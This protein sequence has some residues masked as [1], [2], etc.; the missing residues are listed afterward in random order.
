VNNYKKVT[1]KEVDE[2]VGFFVDTYNTQKLDCEI[3]LGI[4]RGGLVLATMLSY[5][6]D[7]PLMVEGY[8]PTTHWDS[9]I[10][11]VDDIADTGKTLE[12][13]LKNLSHSTVFTMHYHQQSTIAPHAWLYEKKD[14]WIVYPWEGSYSRSIS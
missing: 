10:L 5:K 2:S 1:W 6:L 8:G 3:I 14:E 4:P 9:K 7:L 13:V 12:R 11:V